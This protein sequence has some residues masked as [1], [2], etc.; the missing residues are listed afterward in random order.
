MPEACGSSL[1]RGLNLNR[2][3]ILSR[4]SGN[5]GSLSQILHPKRTPQEGFS[6]PH[7]KARNQQE[8]H[9][10]IWSHK[11]LKHLLTHI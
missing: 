6:E 2:T 9:E 8:K 11:N 10:I 1:C 3:S 4:S 7:T 5:A